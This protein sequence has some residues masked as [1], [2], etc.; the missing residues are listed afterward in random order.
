MVYHPDLKEHIILLKLLLQ[1]LIYVNIKYKN[2]EYK[3]F[4][5]I[6][7]EDLWKNL[8]NGGIN[9]TMT[10]EEGLELGIVDNNPLNSDKY[11]S[12]IEKDNL[13]ESDI[14]K[15]CLEFRKLWDSIPDAEHG[16]GD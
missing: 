10:P 6:S 3:N 4:S 12:E 5:S 1:N 8:M 7:E 15:D 13:S 2:M 11:F 14:E 9:I 16:K